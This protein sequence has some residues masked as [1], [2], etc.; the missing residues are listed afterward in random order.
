[1]ARTGENSGADTANGDDGRLDVPDAERAR[2]IEELRELI[3]EGAS[4]EGLTE[5]PLPGL[6]YFR[7]SRTGPRSPDLYD[8][9]LCI[10]ASGEKKAFMGNQTYTYDPLH[11][12]VLAVPLPIE[13]EITRASEDE[14]F[15]AIALDLDPV[16]LAEVIL[17]RS[18]SEPVS[19]ETDPSPGIYTS[20]IDRDLLGAVT[21]LLRAVKDEERREVLAPLAIREIHFHLLSGEQGDR[22]R[23]IALRD[24]RSHRVAR[25]LR[26]IREHYK[27]PLDVPTIARAAYMSPST[28]HHNFR[29][30]TST[31][32]IQYLK[33]IRLHEARLLMVHEDTTA[34]GAAAEVG[35]NSPSQFSREFRR[36]FGEPPAAH[37]RSLQE[38]GAAAV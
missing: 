36:L 14:P 9:T 24:G 4:G 16:E 2:L 12:R 10:V 38:E 8:P 21:R 23:A 6:A 25:A 37:V 26:Y 34:A 22:L 15:L 7:A 28:L 17:N 18:D 33:R 35:Y 5:S 3:D 13:I 11:Y 29:A 27:E 19:D 31:S 32:P 30:V 20:R 1:M